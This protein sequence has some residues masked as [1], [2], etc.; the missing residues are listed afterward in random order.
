[1]GSFLQKTHVFY[2]GFPYFRELFVL[3]FKGGGVLPVGS[4]VV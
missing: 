4:R 2:I 1:M 3:L